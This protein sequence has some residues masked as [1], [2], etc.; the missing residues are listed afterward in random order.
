MGFSVYL[1]TTS[2][3]YKYVGR[4]AIQSGE[5][6]ATAAGRR[7]RAHV[8]EQRSPLMPHI[9]DSGWGTVY[10]GPYPTE[11]AAKLQEQAVY[12]QIPTHLRLNKV[13]PT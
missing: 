7:A 13:R 1:V 4:T 3:G 2:A 8:T 12:D 9:Q 5:T 6:A 11:A 10:Y